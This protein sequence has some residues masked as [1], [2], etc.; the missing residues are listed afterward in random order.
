M[1]SEHYDG[2]PL[3]GVDQCLHDRYASQLDEHRHGHTRAPISTCLVIVDIDTAPLNNCAMCKTNNIDKVLQM[4]LEVAA[5]VRSSIMKKK[6][7][8]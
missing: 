4:C 1:T 2:K 3:L 6:K 5:W 7:V 8:D